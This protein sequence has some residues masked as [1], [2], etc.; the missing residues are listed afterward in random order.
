MNTSG[1]TSKAQS[2]SSA[3]SIQNGSG[4]GN[5]DVVSAINS[6]GLR[7][8]DLSDKMSKLKVVTDT[9]VLVGQILPEMDYQLGRKVMWEERGMR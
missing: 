6:L 3:Q 1:L 7:L 2:I 4:L 5:R 9:G 8:D